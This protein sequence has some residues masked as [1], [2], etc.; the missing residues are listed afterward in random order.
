LR[1]GRSMRAPAVFAR[2]F[3]VMLGIT[4]LGGCR[5]NSRLAEGSAS[6]SLYVGVEQSVQGTRGVFLA[7]EHLNARRPAGTRPFALKPPLGPGTTSV[8]TATAFRDDPRL[9]GVIGHQGSNQLLE[10]APVYSD[11]AGHERRA[12]PVITPTGTNA[13]LTLVSRW[14]LRICPQDADNAR[15]LAQ[16]AIDSL[17]ARRVGVIYRND[18]F[19]RGFLRGFESAFTT[20][21]GQIIERDPHLAGVTDY[22]TYF[23]RMMGRRPDALVIAGGSSEYEPMLQALHTA[24]AD[25]LPILASDDMAS[26]VGDTIMLRDRRITRYTSFYV[27]GNPI[28]PAGERF[29]EDYLAKWGTVANHQAA[30]AYDAATLLGEAVYAVGADRHRV[31]DW[32]ASVGRTRPPFAGISGEIRFD[33]N[34]NAVKKRIVIARIGQ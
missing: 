6:D 7:L 4:M 29:E 32:L 22:A 26:W 9:I 8:A 11:I 14:I 30:L 24:G 17:H 25:M 27:T 28:S 23:Q 12:V 3:A 10:A 5:G 34:Y 13:Q 33:E 15:A 2:A 18:V 20:L 1:V 19:G 16:F 21:G 31:R